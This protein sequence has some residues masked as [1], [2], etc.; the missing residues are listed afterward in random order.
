MIQ[1]ITVKIGNNYYNEFYKQKELVSYKD[2]ELDP[3]HPTVNEYSYII[4]NDNFKK[5]K[6]YKQ[7][8]KNLD[9]YK[10]Q[11]ITYIQKYDIDMYNEIE[12]SEFTD[13]TS[14]NTFRS[15][16]CDGVFYKEDLVF[17]DCMN[18]KNIQQEHFNRNYS[19]SKVRR[20][21]FSKVETIKSPNTMIKYLGKYMVAFNNKGEDISY[22]DF[23]RY[24]NCIT[25]LTKQIQ[26]ILDKLKSKGNTK[27]YNKLLDKLK[28]KNLLYNFQY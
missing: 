3:N 21:I 20:I 17:Y 1:F 26:S 25:R 11:L 28:D 14:D 22:S 27:L 12:D 13:F 10:E 23:E 4:F 7:I 24:T 9:F 5:T 15:I 8:M 2:I 6:L 19:E 18:I 16:N